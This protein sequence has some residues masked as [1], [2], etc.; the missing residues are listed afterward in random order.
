MKNE[1]TTAIVSLQTALNNLQDVST[2]LRTANEA[3]KTVTVDYGNQEV[4]PFVAKLFDALVSASQ[5]MEA[6]NKA[7]A[8]LAASGAMDAEEAPVRKDS[9]P[10]KSIIDTS[11]ADVEIENGIKEQWGAIYS[12]DG[13]RLLHV[14]QGEASRGFQIK[15]GTEVICDDALYGCNEIKKIDVP[16]S[17]KAIGDNAFNTCFNLSSIRIPDSVEQIGHDVFL[18]CKVLHIVVPAGSKPD[19]VSWYPEYSERVVE[20]G[21]LADEDPNCAQNDEFADKN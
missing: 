19:F 9:D 6:L 3:K 16:D 7:T 21:N 14:P 20:E 4:G 13:K 10:Y 15:E 12:Q 2:M 18:N 1:I 17:V 8:E 11:V 5:A